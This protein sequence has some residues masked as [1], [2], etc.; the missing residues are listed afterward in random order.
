MPH[1][2]LSEENIRRL[3]ELDYECVANLIELHP[4]SNGSRYKQTRSQGQIEEVAVRSAID[5]KYFEWFDEGPQSRQDVDKS[6]MA[7]QDLIELLI[8]ATLCNLDYKA[9]TNLHN[10]WTTKPAALFANQ[11]LDL[12]L[13]RNDP[14]DVITGMLAM[15]IS[16]PRLQESSNSDSLESSVINV[17]TST[18]LMYT[19]NGQRFATVFE[20][21]LQKAEVGGTE[22]E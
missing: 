4:I 14:R 11:I 22:E 20:W 18:S 2:H 1:V 19:D 3:K 12:Q 17:P 5:T 6:L 9:H 7:Q 13:A 15:K 21:A 10:H 8:S 16:R